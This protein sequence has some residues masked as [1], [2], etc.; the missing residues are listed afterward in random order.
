MAHELN[1]NAKGEASIAAVG[2]AK[3]MWHG[4]GQEILKTDSLKT[5]QKKAGLD[6]EALAAPVTYRTADGTDM[7]FKGQQ[8]IYRGDTH[9][10]LGTTSDNRYIIVQP[11]EVMEFFKDFLADNKLS[12]ETAGAVRGGRIIWCLAKLG[13]DFSFLLKGSDKVDGYVRLQTSFDGTRATDLVA[14][15]IRQVCANTM[16]L[17]DVDAD[18]SGYRTPHSVKFDAKGLQQA[19]GLLGEQHKLTAKVWNALME[20]KVSDTEAKQFF[21]DL[22]GVEVSDIGKV[23][24]DGKKIIHGKTENQLL[25]LANAYTSGPGS[26]L[27]SAKGTAYGLLQAVTYYV[28]HVSNTV[29]RYGD[30]KAQARLNSA[31]FG[32]GEETKQAALYH[33][34]ELAECLPLIGYEAVAA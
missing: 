25:A 20:R 11:A 15:S 30:G 2:G 9:E 7:T 17:V 22:Q 27:K 14:T 16:R 1:I 3:S 18:R 6:W 4:L 33:A 24:K 32:S 31:W 12:I 5:I 21:C 19:F 28:D 26:G 23:D 13:K 10:P 29:D 8:V 34:C